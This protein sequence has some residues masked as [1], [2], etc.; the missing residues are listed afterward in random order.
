MREIR[1]DLA[2]EAHEHISGGRGE[3]VGAK[4]ERQRVDESLEITRVEIFNKK[5]EEA[6]GKEQGMYITMQC[7]DMAGDDGAVRQ[8]LAEMLAREI[9]S[10]LPKDRP[11]GPVLVVGLGNSRVTPDSL[12]PLVA[13]KVMVTHHFDWSDAQHE[14]GGF[15]D[16]C[17]MSPGVLGIT[18]IETEQIIFGVVEQIKP[19][20]LICIDALASQ[21]TSR[22]LT[23]IQ[24]A[25]SGIAPGSGVGNHRKALN[26]ASMG[27]PVIAMGVPMVVY[28]SVI[29]QDALDMLLDSFRQEA[30]KLHSDAVLQALKGSDDE[31]MRQ[32][33]SQVLGEDMASLVVTPKDIDDAVQRASQVLAMGINLALHPDMDYE[34]LMMMQ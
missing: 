5:G 10:L 17:A 25:D 33:M 32:L 7:P 3:V 31:S 11:G 6:L 8:K 4:L 16:V 19:G 26:E 18:G 9:R 27:V 34:T 20:C 21:K 12:G 13:G 2:M 22:V 24:L 28:A 23:T 15:G 29:A 1:T 30:E 14:S